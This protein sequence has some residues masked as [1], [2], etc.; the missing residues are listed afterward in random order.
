MAALHS[1]TFLT[2]SV[3]LFICFLSSPSSVDALGGRLGGKTEIVDV[4]S[5]KEVQDLGKYSVDQYNLKFKKGA[6]GSLTYK[7]VVKAESQVVSGIQ[8]FLKVSAIQNGKPKLYDAVVVVKAWETP[9][10]SLV[11]FDPSY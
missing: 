11:S 5:N 8:Y 10:N 1:S 4:E 3:L 2:I 6:K 9:S 7:E